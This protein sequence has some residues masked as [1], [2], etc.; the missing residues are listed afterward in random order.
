MS[1]KKAVRLITRFGAALRWELSTLGQ[2]I[3]ILLILNKDLLL[4]LLNI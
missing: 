4:M 1:V 3:L 2:M